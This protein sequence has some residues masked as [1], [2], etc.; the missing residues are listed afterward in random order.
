MTVQL[1]GL[2]SGSCKTEIIATHNMNDIS[3]TAESNETVYG[4]N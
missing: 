4:W 3:F 2:Y 1:S